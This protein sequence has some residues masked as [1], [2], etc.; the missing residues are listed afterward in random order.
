MKKSNQYLIEVALEDARLKIGRLADQIEKGNIVVAVQGSEALDGK[1]HP[2][3]GSQVLAQCLHLPQCV[4]LVHVHQ[5]V[6]GAEFIFSWAWDP[7]KA[8]VIV[9]VLQG[10]QT[11]G[12]VFIVQLW[13]EIM[14]TFFTESLGTDNVE[15]GGQKGSLCS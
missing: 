6:I 11:L 12:E 3:M 15:P 13:G 5:D 7:L 8:E 14:M 4:P 1:P 10:L 2:V 9:D